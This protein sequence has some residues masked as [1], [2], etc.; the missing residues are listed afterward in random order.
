MYIRKKDKQL[1]EELD[2]NLTFPS[3]WNKFIF[4]IK[5]THNLIIK[6]SSNEFYCTNCKSTFIKN[7]LKI[8]DYYICPKCKQELI[9]RNKTLKQCKFKDNLGLLQR[10]KD[11]YIL[12]HFEIITYYCKERFSTD[13]CE[14]GRQIF[15][16]RFHQMHE[17]INNHTVCCIGGANIRHDGSVL[18]HDWHYFNSYWKSLG[19]ALIYYPYNLKELFNGT[20]W[21]YSQLWILAQKERY[22]SIKYLLINYRSSVELLIKLKLY[23][24]AL[25]HRT[26]DKEGSFEKRFGV[27]KSYLKYMQKHNIDINE[28]DVLKYSKIKDIRI[29]KFFSNYDLYELKTYNI[30]LRKLKK[31]TNLEQT[32]FREYVDYLNMSRELGYDM[33]SKKIL[34]PDNIEEAH[35]KVQKLYKVNKDKKID[36]KIA[37]ISKKLSANI[38]QNKEYIIF[39]AKSIDS[40]INESYQQNNCVQSYAERYA[41]RKCDIYFMRLLNNQD[42][43]LVTVEVRDNKVVQQRIKNNG[44]TTEEQQQFLKLWEEKILNRYAKNKR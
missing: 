25:T 11:Y 32:N 40:L 15:D 23:K 26:F 44:A 37:K 31:F 30:D 24:L 2:E 27:D 20:Q 34:Y 21:Q 13:V 5:K 19:D 28:L 42:K 29:L 43:S 22:F 17:I 39:P 35:Y 6:M 9:I 12:R 8:S 7:N 14:Y 33:K 3:N 41:E 38:Y 36:R 1:F 4:D 18:G 16:D 10:Y